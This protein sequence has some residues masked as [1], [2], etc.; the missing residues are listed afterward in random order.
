MIPRIQ[1]IVELSRST[2]YDKK[3]VAKIYDE[4]RDMKVTDSI[5][6]LA[7]WTNRTPIAILDGIKELAK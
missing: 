5:L 1:I 4:T 2:I 6:S 3:T 7:M